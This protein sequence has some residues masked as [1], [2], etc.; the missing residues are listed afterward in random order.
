[1]TLKRIK[2]DDFVMK[3]GERKRLME[4]LYILTRDT[5]M[6]CMCVCMCYLHP[7]MK[8]ACVVCV[9]VVIQCI[10]GFVIRCVRA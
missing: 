6:S 7:A 5:K 2:G 8:A 10:K 4:G 1:M 3:R 9:C